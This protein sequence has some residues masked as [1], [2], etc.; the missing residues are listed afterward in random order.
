MEDRIDQE[1]S[2]NAELQSKRKKLEHDIDGLKKD[3]DDIR[4]SLQ[5]SEQ[6]C[7]TRDG[8]IHRRE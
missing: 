5:K 4:L 1:E 8:Q 3:I 6:E 2:S 7:K